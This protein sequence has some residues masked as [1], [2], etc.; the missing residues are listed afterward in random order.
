[1]LGRKH[2]ALLRTVM[3]QL[4]DGETAV[5]GVLYAYKRGW[6]ILRNCQVMPGD[7]GATPA[8]GE[9]MI[10]RDRVLFLQAVTE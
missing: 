3:V 4:D 10:H 7:S 2:P 8:D 5:R 6:H 9:M 1:M